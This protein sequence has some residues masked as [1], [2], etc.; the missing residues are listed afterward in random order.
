VTVKV[1][2]A[3]VMHKML[4]D[5]VPDLVKMVGKMGDGL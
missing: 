2:R 1:Q 5:S 3:Q 4:A